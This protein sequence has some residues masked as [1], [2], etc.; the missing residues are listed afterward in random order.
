MRLLDKV[1]EIVRKA[2]EAWNYY[3]NECSCY[4]CHHMYMIGNW[5]YFF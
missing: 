5:H 3:E 2:I 1:K 4:R